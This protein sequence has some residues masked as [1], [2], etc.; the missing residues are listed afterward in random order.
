MAR[1]KNTRCA[2]GLGTIRYRE[3]DKRWEGRYTASINPATGKQEQKSVY[4]KTEREVRKKLSAITVELDNNEWIEPIQTKLDEWSEIWIRDYCIDLKIRT[5][6]QTK[7]ILRNHIIPALGRTQLQKLKRHQVQ[8]FC[9]MLIR[10]KGLSP[11]T[12][13]NIHG[14]LHRMLADAVDLEYIKKNPADRPK[15]P[16]GQNPDINPLEQDEI[17]IF[18][19]AARDDTYY[20]MYFIALFTGMRISEAIGLTWDCV[21][22][23]RGTIKLYRQWT[24]LGIWDTLKNNKTRLIAPAESIMNMLEEIYHEQECNQALSGN[25]WQNHNSHVFVNEEGIRYNH[26][27]VSHHFREIANSIGRNDLTFHGLRH[28]YAVASIIAGDDIKTLSENMGHHSV[29]FTLDKYGHVT[30]SMRRASSNRMEAFMAN[31]LQQGV[32]ALLSS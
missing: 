14:V 16:K 11:K 24:E 2:S 7:G 6:N 29:A 21:N 12:V 3:S 22:F 17:N 19:Q 10:E 5:L 25:Q 15:I 32:S 23:R 30:D 18:L 27:T 9:N 28:S 20:D 4:G 1:R 31:T 13:R 8:Q 26:T